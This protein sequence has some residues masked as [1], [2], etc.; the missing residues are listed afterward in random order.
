MMIFYFYFYFF[1][2]YYLKLFCTVNTFFL[3]WLISSFTYINM[4]LDIYFILSFITQYYKYLLF[5]SN[6]S[7]IDLWEIFQLAPVSLWNV[8][9]LLLPFQLFLHFEN[10]NYP[11]LF[12]TFLTPV[13][14]STISQKNFGSLYWLM[15]FRK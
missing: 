12:W 14:E 8:F 2:F 6:F 15:I 13:V 1:C 3:L 9:I 4:K 11:E 5:C 7:S 10:K